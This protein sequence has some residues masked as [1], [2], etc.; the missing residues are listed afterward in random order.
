MISKPAVARKPIIVTTSQIVSESGREIV[1][2]HYVNTT[3][4]VGQVTVTN[5]VGNEGIVLGS[6][7]QGGSDNFC[8][9]QPM[10]F[11]KIVVTFVTGTGHLTILTS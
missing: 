11:S 2:L 1:A 3:A 6:D 8:P 4:G 10:P 7:A 5:G 9:A